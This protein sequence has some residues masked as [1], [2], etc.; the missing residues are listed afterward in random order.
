MET[1]Q[2]ASMQPKTFEESKASS[3]AAIGGS[4]LNA[5]AASGDKR[6]KSMANPGI[7]KVINKSQP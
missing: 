5:A 1:K 3:T 2:A 4:T 7:A 6:S